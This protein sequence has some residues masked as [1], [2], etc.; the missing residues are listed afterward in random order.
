MITNFSQIE[1]MLLT[2]YALFITFYYTKVLNFIYSLA[3]SDGLEPSEPKAA[4]IA[5]R[6]SDSGFVTGNL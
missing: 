5:Y 6:L 1:K 3:M 4:F 2:K